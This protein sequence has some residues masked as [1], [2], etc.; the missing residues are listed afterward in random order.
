MA[1]V[2]ISKVGARPGAATGRCREPPGVAHG[3][4]EVNVAGERL[5]GGGNIVH[6]LER[7]ARRGGSGTNLTRLDDH[8]HPD[9]VR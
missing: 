9:V 2:V 6:V 3:L 1:R 5:G 8:I 7:A 4:E